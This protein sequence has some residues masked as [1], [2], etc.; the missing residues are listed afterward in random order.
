MKDIPVDA[1]GR[2][3]LT[4]SQIYRKRKMW[5]GG[6]LAFVINK[7]SDLLTDFIKESKNPKPADVILTLILNEHDYVC[8]EPL[9]Y[10]NEQGGSTLKA[11]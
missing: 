6:P 8:K 1:S 9:G 4:N 3:Y 7:K 10:E 5:L 2:V 11:G